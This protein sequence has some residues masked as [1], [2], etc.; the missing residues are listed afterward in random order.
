MYFPFGFLDRDDLKK[1][2]TELRPIIAEAV[3]TEESPLTIDHIDFLPIPY[4]EGT[5]FS[6]QLAF[7]IETLGLDVR[8]AKLSE[9]VVTELKGKIIKIMFEWFIL[10]PEKPLLWLKFQDLRGSHV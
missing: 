7:E 10:D 3:N 2:G 6:Q 5:V 1:I 9:E 8:T 4:I